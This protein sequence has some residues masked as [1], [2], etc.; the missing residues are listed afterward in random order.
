MQNTYFFTENTVVLAKGYKHTCSALPTKKVTWRGRGAG[1]KNKVQELD[2]FLTEYLRI[3]F[4]DWP[5]GKKSH[6]QAN[7]PHIGYNGTNSRIL[8]Q[9]AQIAKQA[10][11]FWKYI[12]PCKRGT[13]TYVQLHQPKKVT[14]RGRGT[15]VKNK[16]QG[17]GPFLTEYLRMIFK[18]W[19]HRKKI[20]SPGQLSAAPGQSSAD[21]TW[22][23]EFK[24]FVSTRAQIAK[25]MFFCWKY[26]CPCKRI[27]TH[28]FSF[29]NQKSDLKRSR[30]RY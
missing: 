19:P 15:H 5:T 20:A 30:R 3:I 4:K 8:C 28:M 24:N 22:W 13:T 12:C 29:T 27:Q 23:D 17:V 7:H 1:I 25:H 9:R 14:L 16:I 26:S 10:F 6:F 18:G 2:L 21:R 11:F